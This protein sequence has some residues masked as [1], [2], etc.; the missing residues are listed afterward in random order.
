M[1]GGA[2]HLKI[3]DGLNHEDE[4]MRD[5]RSRVITVYDYANFKYRNR[6][7]YHQLKQQMP[8]CGT[9]DAPLIAYFNKDSVKKSLNI[10]PAFGNFTTC[11]AINY[12]MS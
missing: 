11:A 12:T 8:K 3:D 5:L 6:Q 2:H 7:D 9:Y 4:Y 1:D 10:D